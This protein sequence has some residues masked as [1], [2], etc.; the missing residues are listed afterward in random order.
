M[1]S[2]TLR[3]KR[4][5]NWR[6]ISTRVATWFSKE[7]QG[8]IYF[9]ML[10]RKSHEKLMK[11]LPGFRKDLNKSFSLIVVLHARP[12]TIRGL[13]RVYDVFAN[14]Q[15]MFAWLA[16]GYRRSR[17]CAHVCVLCLTFAMFVCTFVRVGRNL[18]TKN[19]RVA[20]TIKATERV[21]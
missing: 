21:Y 9:E 14:V 6:K 4:G 10:S 3:S 15:R 7:T 8:F 19:N 16:C 11:R 20:E 17:R 12:Q 5:E 18:T 13:S 2:W 1:L